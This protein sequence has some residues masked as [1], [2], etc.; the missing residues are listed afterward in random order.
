MNPSDAAV[1]AK[2]ALSSL[3][4]ARVR[5]AA[6]QAQDHGAAARP[7]ARGYGMFPSYHP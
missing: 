7:P 6:A 3:A 2:Q 5:R 4:E 1:F